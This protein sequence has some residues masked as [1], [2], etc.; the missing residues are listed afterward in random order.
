MKNIEN[1][2]LIFTPRPYLG[3]QNANDDEWRIDRNNIII[4]IMFVIKMVTNSENE[5][6]L[7]LKKDKLTPF[8]LS[9]TP[10]QFSLKMDCICCYISFN[11]KPI[12][13]NNSSLLSSSPTTPRA[14]DIQVNPLS[15]SP[16]TSQ[17]ISDRNTY[18][19]TSFD[20]QHKVY[21]LEG[22][23]PSDANRKLLEGLEKE[24]KKKRI[25]WEKGHSVIRW[26]KP[27]EEVRRTGGAKRRE[28]TLF[29]ICKVDGV[30]LSLSPS[31]I[32]VTAS[33]CF[34]N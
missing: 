6:D 19:N 7:G 20:L 11:G 4:T 24:V 12:T 21:I 8:L 33:L 34:P 22:M 17:L 25:D 1:S 9:F 3:S 14:V 16:P 10:P 27:M 26:N 18:R 23:K 32:Q 28:G 31:S 13:N 5:G 29:S 30:L 15:S 2:S